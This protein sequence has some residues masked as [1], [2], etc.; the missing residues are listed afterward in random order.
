MVHNARL[1][2]A[3][4]AADRQAAHFHRLLTWAVSLLSSEARPPAAAELNDTALAARSRRFD[5]LL[6]SGEDGTAAHA[7][8]APTPQARPEEVIAALRAAGTVLDADVVLAAGPVDWPALAAAHRREP[9]ARTQR[10]ALIA[11]ADCPDDFTVALLTPWDPRIANRLVARR[12]ELPTSA[13]WPCLDRIGETRP[14]LLRHVLT[15]ANLPEVLRSARYLD[16][17]VRAVN[18]YDHNNFPAAEAFWT[19]VGAVLHAR[20]GDDPRSWYVAAQRFPLHHGTLERLLQGLGEPAK[21][22]ERPFPDLRVLLTAPAA[23]VVAV[24][25]ELDDEEL[26]QAAEDSWHGVRDQ[27]SFRSAVTPRLHAAGV[28]RRA[29]FARWA[30]PYRSSADCLWLYGLDD[31]LDERLV[32]QADHD[33]ALRR[34]LAALGRPLPLSL[35]RVAE[36]RLCTDSVAAQA[37]LDGACGDAATPWPELVRAHATEPLPLPVLYTLAACPGFP[38]VLAQELPGSTRFYW[39][40]HGPAAARSALSDVGDASMSDHVIHRVRASGVLDDESVVAAIQPASAALRHG[41]EQPRDAAGRDAWRAVCAQLVR[42]AADRGGP[43]LWRVLAER[44]PD[45][46]GPLPELLA[47][48]AAEA[49]AG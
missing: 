16:H 6:H 12:Q 37:V 21:G 15:G 4:A 46:E 48:A 20:L 40:T 38:D 45:C 27:P 47:E 14:A 28:P 41:Y 2:T 8:P 36:L 32:R 19:V 9:F 22:A 39:S 35:D 23:V 33:R 3:Q 5:A 7:R 18:G 1:A 31:R 24:V 43:G 17:L 49:G 42:R 10:R 11:R 25:G 29:L 26:E 44:L 30:A 34:G 13:W